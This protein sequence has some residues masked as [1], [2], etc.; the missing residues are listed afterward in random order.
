MSPHE[1]PQL[2]TFMQITDNVLGADIPDEW[3]TKSN[4][5]IWSMV[6]EDAAAWAVIISNGDGTLVKTNHQRGTNIFSVFLCYICF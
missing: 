3:N 2:N 1:I 6:V 4:V 5:I